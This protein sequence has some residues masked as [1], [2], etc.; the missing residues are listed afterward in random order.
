MRAQHPTLFAGLRPGLPGAVAF[1]ALTLTVFGA[2]SAQ[3]LCLTAERTCPTPSVQVG[4]ECTCGRDKGVQVEDGLYPYFGRD[5]RRCVTLRS[6]CS[7][8]PAPIGAECNCAG[9]SGI[10]G[11]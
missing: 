7:T 1:V 3:A 8:R 6:S 10:V 2:P 4:N 11:F 5:G 9:R